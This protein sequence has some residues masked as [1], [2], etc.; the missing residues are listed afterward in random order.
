MAEITWK[1]KM[2]DKENLK[3]ATYQDMRSIPGRENRE[4]FV[5]VYR[6]DQSIIHGYGLYSHYL[7]EMHQ[8]FGGRIIVREGVARRLAE[9]NQTLGSYDPRYRLCVVYGFRDLAIQRERHQAMFESTDPSLPEEQRREIAHSKIA[10]PNVAGHPTGGAVDLTIFNVED[11]IFLDMGSLISDFT[12]ERYLTFAE[13]L[14]NQ[15]M[16]NRLLLDD[17]MVSQGFCHYYGEWWHFCYGEREW[18]Y[19][20]NQP[21]AIYEQKLMAEINIKL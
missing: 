18:A 14:T 19:F 8:Y 12:N 5:E 6:F 7:P 11:Q 3:I 13:G 2:V 21:F 17:V 1:G 10:A 16:E 15:Q 20:Y 9:A 4:P